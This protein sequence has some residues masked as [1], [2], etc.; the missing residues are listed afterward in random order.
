MTKDASIDKLKNTEIPS[1]EIDKVIDANKDLY[2][3]LNKIPEIEALESFKGEEE[4]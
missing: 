2:D 4:L 1:V 3:K